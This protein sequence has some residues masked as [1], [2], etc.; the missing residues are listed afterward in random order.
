MLLYEELLDVFRNDF[1]PTV[2]SN[3]YSHEYELRPTRGAK[4]FLT[5]DIE[6]F[7]RVREV[8]RLLRIEILHQASCRTENADNYDA[9]RRFTQ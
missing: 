9:S 7:E 6:D 1:D 4:F 5:R 3:S 2:S 8:K